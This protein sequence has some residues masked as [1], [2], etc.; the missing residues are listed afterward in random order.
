MSKTILTTCKMFDALQ[1]IYVLEKTDDGNKVVET[2]MVDMG[3]L[4]KSIISLSEK[5]S[6]NTIN[7][8][9][10]KQYTKRMKSQIQEVELQKYN[11]NK[12]IINLVQ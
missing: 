10:F 3:D 11:S 8:K 9:G 5:Y 2:L 12:L 1:S 4:P 6:C 7:I